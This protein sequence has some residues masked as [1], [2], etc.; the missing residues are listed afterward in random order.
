MDIYS[1]IEKLNMVEREALGMEFFRALYPLYKACPNT[2][3]ERIIHSDANQ[4]R[5][6]VLCMAAEW[7]LQGRAQ[8]IEES[9]KPQDTKEDMLELLFVEGLRIM[10]AKIVS[11]EVVLPAT[12]SMAASADVAKGK[13]EGKRR[14]RGSSPGA[15]EDSKRLRRL[16]DQEGGERNPPGKVE[17]P[18]TWVVHPNA[19]GILDKFVQMDTIC[20]F[21]SRV[22]S[23]LCELNTLNMVLFINSFDHSETY[24]AEGH[25]PKAMKYIA[26]KLMGDRDSSGAREFNKGLHWWADEKAEY[27][28]ATHLPRDQARTWHGLARK[29]KR[30]EQ[31]AISA[32]MGGKAFPHEISEGEVKEQLENLRK[33]FDAHVEKYAAWQ[34]SEMLKMVVRMNH[35]GSLEDPKDGIGLTM[36]NTRFAFFRL[37][38]NI[39]LCK[40]AFLRIKNENLFYCFAYSLEGRQADRSI[41]GLL[42]IELDTLNMEAYSWHMLPEEPGRLYRARTRGKKGSHRLRP[43][44][45]YMGKRGCRDGDDCAWL[46]LESL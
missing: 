3:V 6:E 1:N 10:V 11:E 24:S 28:L 5:P 43:C 8:S 20:E 23:L 13:G 30:Q 29:E 33:H 37:T 18:R 34:Y 21:D 16:W 32:R 22:K 38:S 31:A 26:K 9:D 19:Q 36:Y 27:D 12:D 41:D 7:A 44:K 2:P 15:E 25:N 39:N 35:E 40:A 17:D 14:A 45:F 4:Y 46:H 42:G